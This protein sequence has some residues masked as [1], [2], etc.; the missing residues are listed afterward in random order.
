MEKDRKKVYK[1]VMND[2]SF[3]IIVDSKTTKSLIHK[4]Y[5]YVFGKSDGFFARFG[6]TKESDGNLKLGL[7]EILDIEISTVC[8]GV[9][10]KVCSFCYKANSPKGEYMTFDTFKQIIDKMQ[11]TLTQVA[12]GIGDIEANPDMWRMFEYCREI[13][14]IPNLTVN[15]EGIT[16]EI[17][18]KLTSIL[19]ACAVSLYDIDKTYGTVKKL[20]DRGLNQTNIH[21]FLSEETYDKCMK[22]MQDT[23]TD[24]RLKNL[25]AVVFLSLKKKGRAENGF[26]QL[27]QEK[28]NT[29]VEYAFTNEVRIGFDS[30]SSFKFYNSILNKTN[31][32][33]I[34]SSV[35]PCEA[36]LYSSYVDVKGDYYPCS[37]S[38]D[39]HED[40]KEGINV[41][42]SETFLSGVW[43]SEKVEKWRNTFINNR[44]A[45]IACPFYEI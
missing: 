29:L 14:I 16:D 30:C 25:N 34:W 12:F 20:T 19:G 11:R 40:W 33:E 2:C 37:F 6:E 43:Y 35:E 32:N 8:S 28:F 36:C 18:D 38:A 41:I 7:P 26:T 42:N 39:A 13:G 23:K 45:K 17:A 5:N 31:F 3:G 1:V 44:D 15:G 21:A 24:E 22:L 10:N 4:E 27:A 9:N